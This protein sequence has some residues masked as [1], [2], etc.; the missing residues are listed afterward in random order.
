MVFGCAAVV[1]NLNWMWLPYRLWCHAMPRLK[2]VGSI[3]EPTSAPACPKPASRH[4]YTA[5]LH[6][7]RSDRDHKARSGRRTHRCGRQRAVGTG[8]AGVLRSTRQTRSDPLPHDIA[9]G[10]IRTWLRFK[11]QEISVPIVTGALEIRAA[12]RL[13]YWDAAAVAAARALG[14]QGLYSDDMSHGREIEEV[15]IINP[16]R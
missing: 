7:P 13:S 15:T 16:F 14:C 9:A 5:L 11:V 12:H 1:R 2:L 10:L 3:A 6:Q 8:A 4:Q